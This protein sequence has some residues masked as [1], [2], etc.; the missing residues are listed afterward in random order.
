M[1]EAEDK[2]SDKRLHRF[3]LTIMTGYDEHGEFDIAS[4]GRTMDISEGGIKMEVPAGVDFHLRVGV[5]L[6]VEDD[7]MKLDGDVVHLRKKDDG[8][9]ELGVQFTNMS[10]EQ[11]VFLGR[12]LL[13]V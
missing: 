6:G 5:T 12:H 2:R 10:E 8:D 9:M 4:V 1:S 13:V 7:V 3:Y 11:K